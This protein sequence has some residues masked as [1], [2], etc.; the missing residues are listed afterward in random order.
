MISP[1]VAALWFL[2]FE[3]PAAQFENH[4]ILNILAIGAFSFV[5]AH[6]AFGIWKQDELEAIEGYFSKTNWNSD[7]KI[8]R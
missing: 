8:R 7:K 2:S 4:Y 1:I 5:I 6:F 3:T